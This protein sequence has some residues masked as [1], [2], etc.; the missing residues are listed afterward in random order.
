MLQT[1]L[2]VAD[3]NE[4]ITSSGGFF[5]IYD[6]YWNGATSI[7]GDASW[8]APINWGSGEFFFIEDNTYTGIASVSRGFTDSYAGGRVV[9]RHNT[10]IDGVISNHGTDSSGRLRSCLAMDIYGNTFSQTS[11]A[12]GT[13]VIGIRGGVILIHDNTCSGFGPNAWFS[14]SCF[15]MFMASWQGANGTNPWDI[16][17]PGGPFYSGTASVVSV[18]QTV[19]A[20][21]SPN[22]APNQWAGYSI[23]RTTNFASKTDAGFSE[24]KSNTSNTL[25]YH[26]AGGFKADLSFVAGDSFEIWKVDQAL[27]QPGV[28]GGQLLTIRGPSPFRR[29]PLGW[30][31]QVITPCYSWNNTR[32][33]GVHVN[34]GRTSLLCKEGVHY[35]SDTAMPRYTPYTYPHPLVTGN[36]PPSRTRSFPAATPASLRKPWGGKQ[37]QAKQL[38]KPVRRAKENPT[39]ETPEDKENL[40]D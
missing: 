38:T 3:H 10:I 27:D 29:P 39:D 14:L 30:N 24:I 15:R 6:S 9:V 12:K 1:V 32:E 11:T 40:G 31:D 13:Q 33:G 37:K 36:P 7:F 28:T 21:E 17:R 18:G 19:T 35:F 8:H 23:K 5:N 2:G 34:F 26:N 20:S 4:V 25:T 16:N 22:W